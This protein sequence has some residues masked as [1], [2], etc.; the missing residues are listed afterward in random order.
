MLPFG[1]FLDLME[2][3][4][5]Y[6]KYTPHVARVT[7]HARAWSRR[8]PASAAVRAPVALGVPLDPCL[9]PPRPSWGRVP[10]TLARRAE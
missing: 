5:G 4:G 7:C 9:H 6:R 3:M 2:G 8:N 1:S 10:R